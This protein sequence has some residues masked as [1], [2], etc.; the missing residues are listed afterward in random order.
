MVPPLCYKHNDIHSKLINALHFSRALEN[1]FAAPAGSRRQIRALQVPAGHWEAHK[2][3]VGAPAAPRRC[4]SPE[5]RRSP[6]PK[7]LDLR[8]GK[9]KQGYA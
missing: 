1:K 2:E 9:R 6:A 7:T 8:S 5:K 3:P 4:C